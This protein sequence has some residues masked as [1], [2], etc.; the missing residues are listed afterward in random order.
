MRGVFDTSNA[1]ARSARTM[2]RTWPHSPNIVTLS[3][4]ARVDDLNDLLRRRRLVT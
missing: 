1:S 2:G 4:T 3:S